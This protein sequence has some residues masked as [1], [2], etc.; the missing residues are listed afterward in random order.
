MAK[1]DRYPALQARLS[2]AE[3][4]MDEAV[5]DIGDDLEGAQRRPR[6]D[7]TPVRVSPCGE[8]HCR[9]ARPKFRVAPV[10]AF[11]TPVKERPSL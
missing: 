4:G 3:D 10:G 9:E 11:N 1:S 2:A 6:G 5:V 8:R 7:E